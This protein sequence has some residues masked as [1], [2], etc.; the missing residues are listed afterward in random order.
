MI[1]Q[2]K[3]FEGRRLELEDGRV[4]QLSYRLIISESKERPE[5]AV[6]GI[7]AGMSCGEQMETDT[8]TGLTESR[9]TAVGWLRLLA[10]GAVTPLCLAEVL[11]DLVSQQEL[12][13]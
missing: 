4:F 6:Y 1:K 10:D 2:E 5:M 7:E 12:A 13:W 9:E 8:V 3:V 11:D